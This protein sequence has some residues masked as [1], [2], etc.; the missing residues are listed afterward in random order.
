MSEEER[1][2]KVPAGFD[3]Y[4][5]SKEGF[6]E[7]LDTFDVKLSNY[8]LQLLAEAY[9]DGWDNATRKVEKLVI[10]MKSKI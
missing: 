5:G 7:L 2:N 8:S 6:E 1:I 10:E 3:W 9:L 4:P